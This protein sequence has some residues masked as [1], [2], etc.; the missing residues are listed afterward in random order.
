MCGWPVKDVLLNSISSL[1]RPQMGPTLNAP[2]KEVV[3][4]RSQNIITM[5][6]LYDRSFGTLLKRSI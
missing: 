1:N 6:L 2:F 3:G 4:P 5:V